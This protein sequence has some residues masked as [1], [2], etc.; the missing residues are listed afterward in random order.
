MQK[1]RCQGQA[2][3]EFVLVV[4]LFFVILLGAAQVSQLYLAFQ[5]VHYGSF[6]ASRAAIVRPCA[7]FMPDHNDEDHFTPAVF[8]AA[9]LSNMAVASRH[10]LFSNSRDNPPFSWMPYLP[11]TDQVDGLNYN[12]GEFSGDVA[13]IKYANAAYLTAVRRVY[14]SNLGVRPV[15]WSAYNNGSGAGMGI[16]CQNIDGSELFPEQ[17]VPPPGHDLSL[18]VIF[19]YP[20]TIP[21]VNQVIYGLFVNFSSLSDDLSLTQIGTEEEDVMVGPVRRLAQPANQQ[22]HILETLLKVTA[23]YDYD[24]GASARM[25]IFAGELA[26][27]N[28]YPLPIRARCTLTTEGAIRPLISPSPF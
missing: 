1:T 10:D 9:V 14:L 7:A 5:V 21:L 27:R 3:T 22:V 19:I 18:E 23:N 15:E 11:D 25:A 8:T 13:A 4:P 28:W 17:N 12:P 20:M 26:D 16:P 6:A 2:L 24:A